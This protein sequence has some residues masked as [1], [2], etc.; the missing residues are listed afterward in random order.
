MAPRCIYGMTSDFGAE[1]LRTCSIFLYSVVDM[2]LAQRTCEDGPHALFVAASASL[3]LIEVVKVLRR[4]QEFI[5]QVSR[6]EMPQKAEDNIAR[7]RACL[8]ELMTTLPA[9]LEMLHP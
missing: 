6:G 8:Q 3:T 4:R 9:L 1:A 5:A 7:L 2:E